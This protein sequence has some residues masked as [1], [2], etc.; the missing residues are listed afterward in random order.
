[1]INARSLGGYLPASLRDL[2]NFLPN[3][4]RRQAT[5]LT[6]VFEDVAALVKA[7]AFDSLGR[8]AG[9]NTRQMLVDVA[10]AVI[11][12]GAKCLREVNAFFERGDGPTA[13]NQSQSWGRFTQ[14]LL[15]VTAIMQCTNQM[16][17]DE[18]GK[19]MRD[20]SGN[21]V[22]LKG[23]FIPATVFMTRRQSRSEFDQGISAPLGYRDGLEL[24]LKNMG[25][26]PEATQLLDKIRNVV[27]SRG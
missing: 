26:L 4:Y 13:I 1:M 7:N 17:Y 25:E 6:E 15:M 24:L 18:S 19:L 14:D 27:R 9:Q 2:H 11:Y 23:I 21:A 20:D 12:R 3:G 10:V 8:F 16:A 5:S 22:R